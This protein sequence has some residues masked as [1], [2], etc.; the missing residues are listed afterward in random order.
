MA[1]LLGNFLEPSTRDELT[2]NHAH[3]PYRLGWSGVRVVRVMF[4]PLFPLPVMSFYLHQH[5]PL[6]LYCLRNSLPGQDIKGFESF[7]S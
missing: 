7:V 4:S 1:W 6:T 3:G 2:A 5:S